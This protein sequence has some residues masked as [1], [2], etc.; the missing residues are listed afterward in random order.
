MLL[1]LKKI[2]KRYN[3]N[4]ENKNHLNDFKSLT[5]IDLLYNQ[6]SLG[7]L[8]NTTH[9][10]P[11]LNSKAFAEYCFSKDFK[12][13]IYINS[14][15]SSSIN[16][17]GF[18]PNEEIRKFTIPMPDKY[19][20]ICYSIYSAWDIIKKRLNIN[21]KNDNTYSLLTFLD[22]EKRIMNQSVDKNK[23]LEL[24]LNKAEGK[25]FIVHMDISSFIH[26]IY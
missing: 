9:F 16:Y 18:K 15:W 4:I 25:E 26:S 24:F 11:I 13:E 20:N 8:P 22:D 10:M 5:D 23:E 7:Y 17:N 21:W 12:K 6:L 2:R 19:Y 3:M 1:V 14:K